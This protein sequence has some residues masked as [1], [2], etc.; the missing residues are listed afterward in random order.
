M[1][2]DLG[3]LIGET[4]TTALKNAASVVGA[5]LLWI[6]TIWVP[7]INVGTTIA[8][9]Y[10]LPL[11]LSRGKVMNPTAIFDGKYRKYMGEFF[12]IMGLMLLSIIPAFCFMIVP[13]IIIGI[14]WMFAVLLM[15]DREL[16][17]A[18]ALTESTR[19]T[20]GH[21]WTLFFGMF[22]V[23]LI[24]EIA[25]VVIFLI[26]GL[27]N[28][29]IITIVVGLFVYAIVISLGVS[30]M[31]VAYKHLVLSDDNSGAQPAEFTDY[32]LY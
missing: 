30:F 17:P 2:L 16:N 28:V 25:V 18:Q 21:K 26:L 19:Y 13:A 20:Y 3:A 27:I 22:I 15:I 5:S 8:L 24:A 31:G 9:F 4:F 12:T 23:S 10:G 6:L 14:G 29:A 7:Y 32:Q 1:K 11:E